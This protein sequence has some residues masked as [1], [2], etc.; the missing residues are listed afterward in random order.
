ME[1]SQVQALSLVLASVVNAADLEKQI[2]KLKSDLGFEAF[3]LARQTDEK[4]VEILASFGFGKLA[5]SAFPA[6]EFFQKATTSPDAILLPIPSKQL[7]SGIFTSANLKSR[8]VLAIPLRCPENSVVAFFLYK[9]VNGP[10]RSIV[11]IFRFLTNQLSITACNFLS[12]NSNAK[13]DNSDEIHEVFDVSD[14]AQIVGSGK[15]MSEV[16]RLISIVA[17]ADTGVLVSGESGTGKEGVASAIHQ[18]SARKNQPYV[19]VNC[20]AIPANLLESELFGH[21]KGSFTGALQRKK[22]KF[23]MAHKGTLFLDEIGEIP[24]ELQGKLL[25]ALQEGEVARIGALAAIKVNV[26]IVAATNRDL[27]QEVKAGRFRE[28]LYYRLNIFPIKLLPLRDRIGDLPELSNFFLQKT[29]SEN[30]RKPMAFSAETSRSMTLYAWPG[31]VRELQ[32]LVS[33]AVLLTNGNTILKLDFPTSEKSGAINPDLNLKTLAEMEK[34]YILSVLVKC[35][36]RISGPNG[37]AK[38]LGI[39]AT[40]LISKMQKLGIKKQI[41]TNSRDL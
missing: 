17:P 27:M 14:F 40:T 26:R 2:P 7:S 19:R 23:E 35:S 36:H 5:K 3:Y 33:R 37:A 30:N 20:A 18:K 1:F 28:D 25:R 8:S 38:I 34:D 16:K 21:E 13:T 22:G 24:I 15:E 32:N 10:E 29:C 31:N 41:T 12:R 6:D 39:P 9:E 11:R 4:S